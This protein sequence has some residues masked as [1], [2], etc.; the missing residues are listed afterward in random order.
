MFASCEAVALA[1]THA[2]WPL[3]YTQRNVTASQIRLTR[4]SAGG[5]TSQ[6]ARD[7]EREALARGR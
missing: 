3:L 4:V 6:L 2:L 5:V 1:P 7:R